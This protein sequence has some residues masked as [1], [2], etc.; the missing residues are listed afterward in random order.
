MTTM[1]L[2][3]AAIFSIAEAFEELTGESWILPDGK[4]PHP[5]FWLLCYEILEHFDEMELCLP[6]RMNP[7]IEEWKKR[8]GMHK[9]MGE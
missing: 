3:A 5:K 9:L 6:H 7:I 1:N 8:A 4:T 2:E